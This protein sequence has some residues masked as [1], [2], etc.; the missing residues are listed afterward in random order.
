[1]PTKI[2]DKLI[3]AFEYPD[4]FHGNYPDKALSYLETTLTIG[5]PVLWDD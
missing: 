2:V 4:E 3:G 5:G 1:M